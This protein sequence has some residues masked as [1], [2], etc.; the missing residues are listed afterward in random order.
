M[1]GNYRNWRTIYSSFTM[2][3]PHGTMVMCRPV[4]PLMLALAL[5]AGSLSGAAEAQCLLCGDNGTATTGAVRSASDDALDL[6]PLRVSI[7]ADLDFSRLVSGNGGGSVTIDPSTGQIR[8]SGAVEAL[9]GSGFTG[10]AVI[11]GTP[12]RTVRIDLPT[13][14]SLRSSTGGEVRIRDIVSSLP[15]RAQLGPDGRLE[16]S[17]G[18]RLELDGRADGDFRGRIQITVSYE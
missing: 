2:L 4:R 6:T 8:S 18:G 1:Q 16:F 17:I 13:D 9:G 10:R 15:P 7:T 5:F 3:V 11:E 12:G 14:V